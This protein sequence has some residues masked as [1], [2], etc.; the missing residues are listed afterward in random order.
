MSEAIYKIVK[1]KTGKQIYNQIIR[2]IESRISIFHVSLKKKLIIVANYAGLF[3][4]FQFKSV[5]KINEIN[6]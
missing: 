3:T 4:F 5:N 2:Q 6:D 1:K